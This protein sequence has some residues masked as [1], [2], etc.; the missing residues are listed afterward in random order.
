MAFV[1]TAR[2]DRCWLA[3]RGAWQARVG[4]HHPSHGHTRP[5]WRMRM[6]R[7][8]RRGRCKQRQRARDCRAFAVRSDRRSGGVV[9]PWG[10]AP[11]RGSLTVLIQ[12]PGRTGQCPPGGSAT[13]VAEG[14][15][16]LLWQRLPFESKRVLPLVALLAHAGAAQRGC[17]AEAVNVSSAV[18]GERRSQCARC[19][20]KV[21]LT[22]GVGCPRSRA[23]DQLFDSLPFQA[24]LV[25]PLT[26]GVDM[27]CSRAFY[28]SAT[29]RRRA[30]LCVSFCTQLPANKGHS[31]GQ[32]RRLDS[33]MLFT[34]ESR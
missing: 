1:V 7:V 25:K 16:A 23:G 33:A 18:H 8:P 31:L 30:P 2:G 27:K 29:G 10:R 20:R 14:A 28:I 21:G 12:L 5:S 34:G 24:K 22:P 13:L 4:E 19:A 15:A 32:C 17:G 3:S 9:R 6:R 26:G 11:W